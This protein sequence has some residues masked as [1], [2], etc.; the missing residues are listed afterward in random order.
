[1]PKENHMETL[2]S[3]FFTLFT[4]F[5]APFKEE[6][7]SVVMALPAKCSEVSGIVCK[8]LHDERIFY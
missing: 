6:N 7:M 4:L 3:F 1:M 2:D 8:L 5:F